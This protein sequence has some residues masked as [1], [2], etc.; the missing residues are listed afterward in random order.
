LSALPPLVLPSVPYVYVGGNLATEAN[1][2]INSAS[3]TFK[4]VPRGLVT[5]SL[6]V[7]GTLA[8]LLFELKT[9]QLLGARGSNW[10]TNLTLFPFRV[11]DA[12]RTN[13][14]LTTLLSLEYNTTNQPGYKLPAMFATISNLVENSAN[15]GIA[16][17]R[18]VV[19]DIYRI[20]SLLNNTNPATFLSP[21]D[22][23]RRFLW[24]DTMDSNY[25][26][27]ATTAAQF[28]SA[29]G[30]ASVILSS[31]SPRPTTNVFLVVRSDTVGGPC[32]L[33]DLN[34]G[35]PTMALVNSSGLPFSFPDNFEILPGSL[36]E[37]SGYS[38]AVSAG[39][40]YPA[41]EVVSAL[42]C[43]V[44]V[45]TDADADGNLLIDTWENKFFGGTG[46][47]S[48]FS[49]TDGDGYSDLQ[50]MLEGSD[51]RDFFGRPAVA[52]AAFSAPV[53]GF[54]ETGG[55]VELHF[56]W[57]A[58]YIGKFNFGVRHTGTLGLPF[59]DLVA[60]GP[61]SVSGNEFKMTFAAP[62]TAQHFY[63]L[64]VALH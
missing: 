31:V 56:L 55:T 45:S 5:N 30:G 21:V 58:A 12:G 29:I 19:R 14:A 47:T 37:V 57:P 20:N 18:Q 38:D 59:T 33:L 60:T 27:W 2:W 7:N 10:W 35:G 3:N 25:L 42:L 63:Y 16:S 24:N 51:P 62:A 61:I 1:N 26:F 6:T 41:I 34:G 23:I 40:A 64:T 54:E 8:T 43:A 50:E 11:S 49:D 48:P 28:P 46:L 9:A 39:C 44:P 22:E 4:S 36:V 17:L 52:V 15:A 13:P 53:L 32:R